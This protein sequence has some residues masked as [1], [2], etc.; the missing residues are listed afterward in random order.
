[1]DTF[2]VVIAVLLVS[3]E[4]EPHVL[5]TLLCLN[6]YYYPLHCHLIRIHSAILIIKRYINVLF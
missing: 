4:L 3:L 1:M 5:L 6:W 2:H